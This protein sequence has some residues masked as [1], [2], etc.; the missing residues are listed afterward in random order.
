MDTVYV[1]IRHYSFWYGVYGLCDQS[2]N[3]EVKIYSDKDKTNFL[4]YF[5]IT[6]SE[7]LKYLLN[8]ELDKIEDSEYCN[9]IEAFLKSEKVM[10]YSYIYPRDFHDIDDQVKHFAPTNEKG[11]KP[12]YIYMWTKQSESLGINEIKECVKILA[13]EFLH[14]DVINVEI[15]DIPAYEE[16]K[17]AFNEDFPQWA[18]E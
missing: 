9:E 18:K 13:K 6:T 16:T 11:E 10:D 8:N 12:V 1:H 2:G 4:G 5:E 15:L 3:D 17:L 14:E 7:S